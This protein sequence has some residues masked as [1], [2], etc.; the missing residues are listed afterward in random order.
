MKSDSVACK[1]CDARR[2]NSIDSELSATINAV[3][4]AKTAY[5]TQGVLGKSKYT[6]HANNRLLFELTLVFSYF[7]IYTP[8]VQ[9]NLPNPI[10][11]NPYQKRV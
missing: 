3:F 4:P 1:T 11:W 2:A 9:P 7:S 10:A 8:G 5:S 6:K